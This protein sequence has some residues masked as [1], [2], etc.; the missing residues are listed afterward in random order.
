[1]F[2]KLAGA[3]DY[4]AFLPVQEADDHA[5]L[6]EAG[7]QVDD[8][9]SKPHR[10]VPGAS[11]HGVTVPVGVAADIAGR[12]V[13]LDAEGQAIRA[14][15]AGHLTADVAAAFA[16]CDLSFVLPEGYAVKPLEL[17]VT[18]AAGIGFSPC[19]VDSALGF[20]VGLAMPGCVEALL[21]CADPPFSAGDVAVDRNDA[22]AASAE[23]SPGCLVNVGEVVLRDETSQAPPPGHSRG[24]ALPDLDRYVAAGRAVRGASLAVHVAEPV[25]C[26]AVKHSGRLHV[27][28]LIEQEGEIVL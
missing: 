26:H 28:D 6:F 27:L 14:V 3:Q 7:L 4:L 15:T 19:L 18:D 22:L 17:V 2:G 23:G 9:P 10:V 11:D 21:D 12:V 25:S 1:M 5:E 20:R 8:A 13:V 24:A 16:P